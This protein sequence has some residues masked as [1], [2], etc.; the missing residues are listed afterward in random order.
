MKGLDWGIRRFTGAQT[1]F[2]LDGDFRDVVPLDDAILRPDR[3]VL[4]FAIGGDHYTASL[5]RVEDANL[6]G[7]WS[8]RGTRPA[9]GE[10]EGSLEP[11]KGSGESTQGSLALRGTWAESGRCRSW[12]VRLTP[13]EGPEE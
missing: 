11:W 3:L 10:V 2:E 6:L 5:L 1:T 8:C 13:V 12:F 4:D 7:T 9:S